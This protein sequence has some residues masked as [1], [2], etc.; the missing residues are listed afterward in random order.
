MTRKGPLRSQERVE[1]MRWSDD[2]KLELRKEE[3]RVNIIWIENHYQILGFAS[4]LVIFT[5][6]KAQNTQR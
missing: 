1:K 5:L 3:K 6:S 4:L 2:W